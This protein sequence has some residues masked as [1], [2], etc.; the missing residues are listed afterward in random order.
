MK[1]IIKDSEPNDLL[2]YRKAGGKNYDDIQKGNIGNPSASNLNDRE[3]SG[4]RKKLLENQGYLCAFCMKRIPEFVKQEVN[5]KDGQKE[6]IEKYDFKI[7][8]I[9]PQESEEG[10]A[11]PKLSVTYTNMVA[12]CTGNQGEKEKNT[13]CD[14]KQKSKCII[15][16][17]YNP[18]YINDLSY[19]GT[20]EI[21]TKNLGFDNDIKKTLNLNEQRLKNQRKEVYDI[22]EKKVKNAYA[23]PEFP[24][25]EKNKFLQ[26]EIEK[27]ERKSGDGKFQPFCMVAICYLKSKIR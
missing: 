18:L 1:L 17:V 25:A 24:R 3:P 4:L 26:A 15:I 9:V 22:I 11:N 12:A 8:H 2:V 19:T 20:G 21:I 23:K 14:T 27:W 7:A 16:D 6:I 10:K 13:T 5:G